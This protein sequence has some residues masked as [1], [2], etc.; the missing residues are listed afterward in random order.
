MIS[1]GLA[2]TGEN[3]EQLALTGD[4]EMRV[5]EGG[6]TA[7]LA[8]DLS[9]PLGGDAPED[10]VYTVTGISGGFLELVSNPGQAITSFT[11]AERKRLVWPLWRDR[12][13]HC[14]AALAA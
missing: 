14:Y 7:I 11:Q 2:A 10:I 12:V 13:S 4:G 6:R 3:A 9:A 5:L 8:S 1:N